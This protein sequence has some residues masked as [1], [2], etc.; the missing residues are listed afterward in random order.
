MLEDY[1]QDIVES[2][3]EGF[4][5]SLQNTLS[6]KYQSIRGLSDFLVFHGKFPLMAAEN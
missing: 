4:E 2:N 5:S 1:Q 6:E 3:T